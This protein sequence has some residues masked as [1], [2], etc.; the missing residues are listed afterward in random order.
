MSKKKTEDTRFQ[1]QQLEK[2]LEIA[3]RMVRYQPWN[4]KYQRK[5]TY[6]QTKLAQLRRK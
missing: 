6:I 3:S 2:Q 1:I 4:D 5:L